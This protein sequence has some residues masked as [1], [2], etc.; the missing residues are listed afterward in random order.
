MDQDTLDKL[1]TGEYSISPRSGR[2]RKRI[3]KKKKESFFSSRNLK[4]LGTKIVWGLLILAFLVSLI[5]VFPELNM[6]STNKKNNQD[7]YSPAK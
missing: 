6:V 1:A 7:K 4:T 5:L 2:L 3:K